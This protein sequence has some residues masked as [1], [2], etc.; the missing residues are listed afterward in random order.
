M[1]F[2]ERIIEP[3]SLLLAW[4]APESVDPARRRNVVGILERDN[5]NNIISFR[6]ILKQDLMDARKLGFQSYGIYE[7]FEYTYAEGVIEEF[8]RRLPP[9]KRKDYKK[10][11]K[12][13]RIH[14]DSDISDFALLGYSGAL[15]PSDS[16]SLVNRFE[17]VEGNCQLLQEIAGF[18]YHMNT[19]EGNIFMQIALGDPVSF[20]PEL[21][22]VFDPNAIEVVLGERRIGYVN[23]V[24]APTF[25]K[26]L[27]NRDV[28]GQIEKVAGTVER[29]RVFIFINVS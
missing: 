6:Y 8:S 24:L 4:Q 28:T 29:P 17:D 5:D 2:I 23:K 27:K 18:R 16:F 14:P 21:D 10:Y 25:L 13:L 15:L 20:R 7:N 12:S 1:H 3:K 22:N 9:R 11:L 26:W 19:K